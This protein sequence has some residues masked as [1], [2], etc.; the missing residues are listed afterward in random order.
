MTGT[1][2]PQTRSAART[3]AVEQ[4]RAERKARAAGERSLLYYLG[5]ALSAVLLL[6]VAGIAALVIVVPLVVG[7]QALT[8]L[9][10]SMA[11]GLPPG[12]LIVIKPVNIDDVLVG[13]V[14]T[15]QIESGKPAVVTHRVVERTVNLEGETTLVTKGDNNDLADDP[16]QQIQVRGKLMYAVPWIGW[17][18]NIITGE[19]RMLAV[20]IVAGLL[21]AY[22]L[23]MVFGGIR[24][25]R[26]KKAGANVVL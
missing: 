13:D 18:N 19:M 15:Y 17:V 16:I 7:G 26:R 14:I 9:T 2:L 3:R 10:N 11:P 20:P 1:D 4:S 21:F 8:V 23:W 6:A 24:D 5:M 12:T 22:A 25:R